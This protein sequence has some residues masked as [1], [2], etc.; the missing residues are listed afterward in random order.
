ML[1]SLPFLLL[2]ATGSQ[3]LWLAIADMTYYTNT[4][5]G[6]QYGSPFCQVGKGDNRD[7]AA[8]QAGSTVHATALGGVQKCSELPYS[9]GNQLGGFWNDHGTINYED[10]NWHWYCNPGSGSSGAC[11]AGNGAP[12]RKR[13][14]DGVKATEFVA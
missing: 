9:K 2:A 4:N 1:K 10:S 6:G 13:S 5:G 12:K 14:V 8:S 3:A 11:D 7:Q